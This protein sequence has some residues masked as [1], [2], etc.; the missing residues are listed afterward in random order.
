VLVE[1][2]RIEVS[3][4]GKKMIA[5]KDS[6]IGRG[7]VA[8]LTEQTL[9]L[10][11]I[12]DFIVRALGKKG[13]YSK[14][15]GG[16]K[17][18]I[19]ENSNSSSH[20]IVYG[21]MSSISSPSSSC[22]SL[23]LS[24]CLSRPSTKKG[25]NEGNN[26]SLEL[27]ELNEPLNSSTHELTN[28]STHEPLNSSTHDFSPD[29]IYQTTSSLPPNEIVYY[30][31]HD[32][33]GNIRAVTDSNGN[34][35]ER[36]DFYPFGEE[37]SQTQSKDQYL[38][39]GKPRDLETGLDYFGARYY[40]SNLSRF[41]TPDQKSISMEK[42]VEP[43]EWNLYIYVGNN[44][45]KYIDPSGLSK[46]VSPSDFERV[47]FE[48]LDSDRLKPRNGL[49]FCNVAVRETAQ[50]LFE[51]DRENEEAFKAVFIKVVK[52]KEVSTTAT[53]IYNA[54]IAREDLFEQ[55]DEMMAQVIANLGGLV[56]AAQEGHVAIV[57]PMTE[58]IMKE[59]E[60]NVKNSINNRGYNSGYGVYPIIANVGETNEVT[61]I[62]W[63]F[64]KGKG[65]RL[66]VEKDT[67]RR[68]S[69]KT[70]T[71]NFLKIYNVKWEYQFREG[72]LSIV[73]KSSGRAQ[74]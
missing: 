57:A 62:N 54:L 15:N 8:I 41:L 70:F 5:L 63:R 68:I 33:L 48:M 24:S 39:T 4:D 59:A 10:T 51:M 25:P 37:I 1:G 20:S 44:P 58:N 40:S 71:D 49:T 29:P 31:H 42:L 34:V 23:S 55:V 30:Y 50:G 27:N 9:P 74:Q 56:I 35:V 64:N 12:D 28:S 16:N 32:H 26:Y 3:V 46:L 47:I 14:Q 17:K 69:L 72:R 21:L 45:L 53:E 19:A 6:E 65:W 7:K 67:L 66:F 73:I 36:H 43:Q 38:F 13:L 2:E 52:E 60:K 22:L 11:V 18:F 61:F